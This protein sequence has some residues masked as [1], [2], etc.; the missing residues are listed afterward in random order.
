[1][2][3]FTSTWLSPLQILLF[4]GSPLFSI[5][6]CIEYSAGLPL[7]ESLQIKPFSKSRSLRNYMLFY[8]FLSEKLGH[9]HG[10]LYCDLQQ[11]KHKTIRI[12]QLKICYLLSFHYLLPNIYV[13]RWHCSLCFCF[14][15]V[16]LRCATLT[17]HCLNLG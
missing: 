2:P 3:D 10:F 16:T 9:L 5:S 13:P 6:D 14:E 4:L 7:R 8:P 1:L 15:E 11:L 12:K 17:S